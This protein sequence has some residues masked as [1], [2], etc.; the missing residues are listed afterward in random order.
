MARVI[1]AKVKGSVLAWARDSAGLTTQEA[2]RRAG[3]TEDKLA[4]WENEARAPTVGQLQKLANAYR[5][6][7]AVFYL[8]E[9]PMRFQA[10]RDFRRMPGDG[11]V[12]FSPELVL[13]IRVAHQRRQLAMELL[14]ESGEEIPRFELSARLTDNPE[15]VG[16]NIRRT[17][18]VGP[19]ERALWRTDPAGYSAFNS[20]RA[21]IEK[22]HA[23]VFQSSRITAGEVSGFAIAEELLPAI[24]VSRKRTSVRRRT[25]SLLH[26]LAHVM[27]R[28][29]GVSEL[30]V[31]AARPPEEQ[32]V[33]IFCNKVAAATLMPEE[34][35]RSEPQFTGIRM[36]SESWT[37]D[38]IRELAL[39][40]SVSREA[41]VRRM[42][43]LGYTTAAFY[44]RKRAQYNEEFRRRL[45][46]EREAY[47]RPGN[48]FKT[49]PP[50][51]ALTNF[52]TPL[53][54]MILGSYYQDRMTLSDVS[55]YLG[56]RTRHIPRLEQIVGSRGR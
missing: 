42:Q 10:M 14:Q 47:K 15:E 25:F 11:P 29:S 38:V 23:L 1:R 28:L 45:E 54:Q 17:L 19:A 36:A 2:A 9:P 8:Q 56:I 53:V 50:R 16:A 55:G 30:D 43:T 31:D 18:G 22:A 6:P 51:D 20:W 40:Y 33:E 5:R 12:A 39:E 34:S 7:L 32:R 3:T 41:F 27:L 26:E 48:E 21:R 4:A 49:N 24:V 44:R 35:V 13:E 52:G 37:D 46:R